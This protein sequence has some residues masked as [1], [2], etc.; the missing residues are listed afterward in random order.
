MIGPEQLRNLSNRQTTK[1]AMIQ[2][3]KKR[4][5]TEMRSVNV[6][7]NLSVCQ[8]TNVASDRVYYLD[9]MN[10]LIF[11]DEP[12]L[13]EMSGK[14]KSLVYKSLAMTKS[15]YSSFPAMEQ[16]KKRKDTSMFIRAKNIKNGCLAFTRLLSKIYEYGP[17]SRRSFGS[18]KSHL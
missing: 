18:H 14:V 17:R 8:Y 15:I 11:K 16:L 4:H 1:D 2:H 12:R 6:L 10:H 9:R 3:N 13:R 7:G 5:I